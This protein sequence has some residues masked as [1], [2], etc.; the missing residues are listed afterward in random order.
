MSDNAILQQL[1]NEL[2]YRNISIGALS[3]RVDISPS[4]LYDVLNGRS[5]PRIDTLID[6]CDALDLEIYIRRKKSDSKEL[7]EN[8][9]ARLPKDKR[10]FLENM[11][12]LLDES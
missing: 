8:V 7:F 2:K 5:M 6:I 1:K 9:I 3:K 11:L 12:T 4:T 10:D